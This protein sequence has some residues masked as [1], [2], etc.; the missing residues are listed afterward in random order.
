MRTGDRS[1]SS[2]PRIVGAEG[3]LTQLCTEPSSRRATGSDAGR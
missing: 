1:S 2:S 3:A